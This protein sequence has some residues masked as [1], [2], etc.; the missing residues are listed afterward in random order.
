MYC[1]LI[2]KMSAGPG[3]LYWAV[4]AELFD[5]NSRAV[6]LS[7]NML[8]SGLLTFVSTRIF[9]SL[10]TSIGPVAT[11]WGFGVN[12]LLFCAYILIIIPETKGKTFN[13]IQIALGAKIDVDEEKAVK[14]KVENKY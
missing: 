3:S 5:S 7:I 13:E 9:P 4:S 10:M 11:Y 12:C 8:I 6:G 1:Q 14:E 2:V